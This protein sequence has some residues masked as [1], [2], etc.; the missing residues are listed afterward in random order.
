MA[1]RLRGEGRRA[2][3]VRE[4]ERRTGGWAG[5]VGWGVGVSRGQSSAWGDEQVL[6]RDGGDAVQNINALNFT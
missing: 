2:V 4:T 6:G 5:G 1:P 3:R